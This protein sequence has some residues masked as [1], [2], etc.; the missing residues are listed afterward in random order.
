MSRL[1][2]WNLYAEVEKRITPPIEGVVHSA[3]FGTAVKLIGRAR[4]AIGGRID[5][6]AASVL[7]AANLP[8]G[9]DI[10]KLRRQI[11][12]LDFEV[13]SLRRELAAREPDGPPGVARQE[14]AGAE[15]D[16]DGERR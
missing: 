8:A 4:G 5:A 7:H 3:E 14:S 6:V 1:S 13:R 12:E 11:G 10:R 2:P 9:S 16:G 15:R